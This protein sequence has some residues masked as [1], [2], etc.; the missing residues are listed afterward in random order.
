MLSILIPTY[1]HNVYKLVCR[2]HLEAEHLSI[3][4]EIIVI[5]DHSNIELPENEKINKL[6]HVE[7]TVLDQNI[8]RAAV[9]E[10]LARKAQYDR[11]L[12]L[13][14]DVI[15]VSE[16]FL[17][18]YIIELKK[19]NTEVLFGGVAYE[20]LTPVVKE[21][22][23]WHYGRKRESGHVNKRLQQPHFVS[24]PNLMITKDLFQK[25]NTLTENVYGDDLVLSQ[26]LKN[27]RIPV[28][29]IDN[30]VYHLGLETSKEY[31]EK[32]L[33][34]VKTI[35]MLERRGELETDFTTLQKSYIQLRKW[36][37]AGLLYILVKGLK[38][39]IERNLV[40]AKPSLFCFDLYRL[41]YY[42][43]LKNRNSV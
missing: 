29:H 31:L 26:Q 28:H 1:N 42:I 33:S 19:T 2:L 12:F 43:E 4:Y 40:S 20:D 23:R 3:P 13:D 36:K 30:P 6:S 22:L 10:L 37:V 11:L 25:I 14:A 18:E 8:G 7:Y 17:A 34:A 27:E 15:P 38:K 24:S 39:V 32:A 5:D 35:V 16:T 21:R 41:Q 9:R